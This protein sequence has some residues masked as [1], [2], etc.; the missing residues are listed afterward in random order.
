[1]P[2]HTMAWGYGTDI[3]AME[4]WHEYAQH[5]GNLCGMRWNERRVMGS[6]LYEH[7]QDLAN[8]PNYFQVIPD[9]LQQS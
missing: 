9:L 1:M 8:H 3:A 5:G 7:S 6:S 2:C 4:V